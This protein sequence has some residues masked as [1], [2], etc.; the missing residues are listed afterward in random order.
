MLITIQIGIISH[1]YPYKKTFTLMI[2]SLSFR[3]I[4]IFIIFL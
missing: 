3:K 4:G 2:N 1:I